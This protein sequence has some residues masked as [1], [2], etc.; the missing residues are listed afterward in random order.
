MTTFECNILGASSP[1]INTEVFILQK[2][3]GKVLHYMIPSGYDSITCYPSLKSYLD[4]STLEG[5][6][7]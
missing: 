4:F 5:N 2:K 1:D 3:M 6:L 7:V